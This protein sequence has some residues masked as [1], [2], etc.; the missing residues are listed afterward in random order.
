MNPNPS[1]HHSNPDFYWPVCGYT[2]RP[3]YRRLVECS[4]SPSGY[5]IF[6]V[7]DDG[8]NMSYRYATM[9][10]AA[11]LRHTMEPGWKPGKAQRKRK[12]RAG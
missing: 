8:I 6:I 1:I 9:R 2:G 12:R 7:R 10:Q 3:T 5:G 4:H 11:Q